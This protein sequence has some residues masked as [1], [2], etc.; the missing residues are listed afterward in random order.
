M[1]DPERHVHKVK[2]SDFKA[3]QE[4]EGAI[5]LTMDNDSVYRLAP[6]QLWPDSVGDYLANKELRE[7]ARVIVEL[8]DGQNYEEFVAVGGS[9]QIVMGVIE[10]VHGESVPESGASS[11]S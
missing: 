8:L 5:D 6:P 10:T 1:T 4:D 2:L 11:S 7:A 9:A 3:K